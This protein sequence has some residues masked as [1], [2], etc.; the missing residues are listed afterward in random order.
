MQETTI[1]KTN[2]SHDP[3][4]RILNDTIRDKRLSFKARG[5]LTFMLGHPNNWTT[6]VGWIE[7]QTTEGREAIRSAIAELES[8]GYLRREKNRSDTGRHDGYVWHWFEEPST[9]DG[10]SSADRERE[11]GTRL[12]SPIKETSDKEINNSS[13]LDSDPVEF[14]PNEVAKL[15][16]K[17]CSSL[18]KVSAMT[19]SR[20]KHAK[21]RSN[22]D[23]SVLQAAFRR[24]EASDFIAGRR[25]GKK[26]WAHIDWL[27]KPDNWTKLHEG[28]YDNRPNQSHV[29]VDQATPVSQN[30]F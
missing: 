5:L 9:G 8:L 22:G 3:F 4:T 10:F 11:T 18:P 17:E 1:H 14:S 24:A 13:G 15:W 29:V 21:A 28:R 7:E 12:P 26:A 19:A 30:A 25:D 6:R 27:L 16:N 20:F 2:R 23:M